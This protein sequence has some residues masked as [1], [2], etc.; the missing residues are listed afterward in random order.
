MKTGSGRKAKPKKQGKAPPAS[1]SF[2]PQTT[3]FFEDVILSKMG[4]PHPDEMSTKILSVDFVLAVPSKSG[5]EKILQ[6]VKM[7]DTPD[8]I[9]THVW[10]LI[11]PQHNLS[12]KSHRR[13]S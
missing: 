1:R 4:N 5:L 11:D 12:K 2:V 13:I 6:R 8:H 3:T 9:L 10:R 7:T